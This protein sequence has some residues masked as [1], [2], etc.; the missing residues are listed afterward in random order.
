MAGSPALIS[1][2]VAAFGNFGP[3]FTGAE[4][5]VLLLSNAVAN[6][7][8]WPVAFHS[9]LA[10]REGVSRSDVDAI[11]DG[12]T[13]AHPRLAALSTVTR[14]LIETRGHLDD[15][16]GLTSLEVLDIVTG[17]AI[18]TLANYTANV[19]QPPLDEPFQS[20]AWS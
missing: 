16:S 1:T 14:R 8:A 4:R 19:A 10:L 5:Q 2:F 12:R 18:S 15:A 3:A 13:P 17:I 6:R 7:S 9:T 20:E 11:R